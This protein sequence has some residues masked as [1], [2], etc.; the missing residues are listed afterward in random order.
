MPMSSSDAGTGTGAFGGQISRESLSQQAYAAIRGSLK[1]SR[2]K[3]G[4]KLVARQVAQELGISVTPVRE[5]LLRL[6][7]EHALEMDDRSTVFVPHLSLDRCMDIR[8]LRM[9]NEGEAAAR[10]A[11]RATKTE[12]D[13]LERTHNKYLATEK[14]DDFGEALIQNENFHFSLCRMAASPVMFGV[15]EN[16]WIQF[17]PVLSYLYD[18]GARPFH[19]QTHGHLLVI[20]AL[21]RRDAEAARH[22]IAQ[23]ILVGG[24]AIIERLEKNNALASPAD[25]RE[26]SGA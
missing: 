13:A 4:Q 21:R 24:E 1:R 5:S 23:D 9:L 3:P 22:A 14:Q 10:A 20:D 15:V 26:E 25:S 6:V 2:L 7:S 17:G 12:I 11:L 18:T 19:G 8:D 16:L